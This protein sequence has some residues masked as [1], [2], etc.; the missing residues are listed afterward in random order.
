[1]PAR[2][3][4]GGEDTRRG[5]VDAVPE[6]PADEFG[7]EGGAGGAVGA[8]ELGPLPGRLEV[9]CVPEAAGGA[10]GVLVGVPEV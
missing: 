8:G 2:V 1:L 7:L 9:A 4:R 6:A 10:L 3:V 5:D